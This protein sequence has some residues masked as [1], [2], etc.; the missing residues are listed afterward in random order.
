MKLFPNQDQQAR[1]DSQYLVSSSLSD[2]GLQLTFQSQMPNDNHNHNYM[3]NKYSS[4]ND[5][6]SDQDIDDLNDED[7]QSTLQGEQSVQLELVLDTENDIVS[8]GDVIEYQISDEEDAKMME[9]HNK[10][11]QNKKRN[12][13]KQHTTSFTNNNNNCKS[14][15]NKRRKLWINKNKNKNESL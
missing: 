15:S 5:S 1:D 12:R 2:S 8:D 6:Q 9:L 13:E 4:C 3:D 11:T 14:P 7:L 10:Q